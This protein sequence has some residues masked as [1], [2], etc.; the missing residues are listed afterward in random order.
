MTDYY[1]T[2]TGFKHY[3]GLAP[4]RIGNLIRC[5][6]EPNNPH[7]PDA[8]RCFL[9]QI[10]TVGYVA[11]SPSTAAGGTLSAGRIYDRVPG[12]FYV[13]VC[14]TTQT[15]IICKVDLDAPVKALNRELERQLE[16]QEEWDG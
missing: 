6:K 15:K 2:I 9:P 10:G 16:E 14:F 12:R 3:Y 13:R 1:V 8:I 11:N 7:D 5:S 4:F